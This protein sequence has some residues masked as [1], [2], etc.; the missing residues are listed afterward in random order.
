MR[1]KS[2]WY[3]IQT[4]SVLCRPAQVHRKGGI[5]LEPIT[6]EHNWDNC[7]AQ[8]SPDFRPHGNSALYQ[9]GSPNEA[10]LPVGSKVIHI[11][12]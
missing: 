12:Q 9:H 2:F 3:G 6:I 8:L 10:P 11:W 1:R 4:R 7:L 5:I